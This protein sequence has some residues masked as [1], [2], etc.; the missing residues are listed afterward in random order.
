MHSASW[1]IS[2]DNELGPNSFIFSFSSGAS[3]GHDAGGQ[4]LLLLSQQIF[5]MKE[6]DKC[7][8]RTIIGHY[9]PL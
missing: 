7:D 6:V 5:L 4:V 3:P 1:C 2:V 9:Q 8:G